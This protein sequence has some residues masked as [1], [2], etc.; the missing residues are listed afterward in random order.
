[1]RSITRGRFSKCVFVVK[2]LY[3]RPG[4]VAWGGLPFSNGNHASHEDTL[5]WTATRR[6][7]F[8][9]EQNE[10]RPLHLQQR[11][12]VFEVWEANALRS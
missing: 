8:H 12:F 7:L 11:P 3:V 4:Q 1:M 9:V 5:W 10:E 6:V 2:W